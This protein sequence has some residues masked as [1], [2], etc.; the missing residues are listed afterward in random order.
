MIWDCTLANASLK[1]LVTYSHIYRLVGW[2]F[3]V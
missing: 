3:W 1:A 2:L